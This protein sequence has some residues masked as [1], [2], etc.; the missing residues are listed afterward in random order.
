M[1]KFDNNIFK[2][3]LQFSPDI[4]PKK[5]SLFSVV[6]RFLCFHTKN[7]RSFAQ[8][9]THR[10]VLH[11][12]CNHQI[13]TLPNLSFRILSLEKSP[14]KQTT[15]FAPHFHFLVRLVSGIHSN[16]FVTQGVPPFLSRSF[17]TVFVLTKGSHPRGPPGVG[18]ARLMDRRRPSDRCLPSPESR[19]LFFLFGLR[20]NDGMEEFRIYSVQLG[21]DTV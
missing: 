21:N 9:N 17:V 5:I 10:N 11:F 18:T 8:K 6:M 1:V 4:S 13:F 19:K 12:Q 7:L 15:V 20:S 3:D 2:I 14:P 16:L